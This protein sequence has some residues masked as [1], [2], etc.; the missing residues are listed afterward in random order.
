MKN[1]KLHQMMNED[2]PSIYQQKRKS[3]TTTINEI[4]KIY[5]LINSEVF[6]D[7]LPNAKLILKKRIPDAWGMCIGNKLPTKTKSGCILII[8]RNWYCK[9]WLI[10]TIAHEMSHQYQWDVIGYNRLQKNKEPLMSHGPTFY[11]FR[12]K[13]NRVG[14]PL[15]RVIH[16]SNWFKKQNLLKC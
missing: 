8:G 5:K 1:S 15:K 10:M 6:N 2:L 3:Y 11:K 12:S 13:M 9:Q 7:K 4:R 16:G 14:I